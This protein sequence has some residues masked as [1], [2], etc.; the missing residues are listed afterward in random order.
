[1]LQAFFIAGEV[2]AEHYEINR[3]DKRRYNRL[4][5]NL[6]TRLTLHQLKPLNYKNR[7]RTQSLL[8]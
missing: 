1:M 2:L 7:L 3:H 8:M 4:N 6:K 5:F